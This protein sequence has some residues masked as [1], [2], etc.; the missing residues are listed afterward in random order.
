METTLQ[1]AAQAASR[2]VM[3]ACRQARAAKQDP[4]L[5]TQLLQ[6][7]TG[8]GAAVCQALYA[9]NPQEASAALKAAQEACGSCLE[10]LG[11]LKAAGIPQAGEALALCGQLA[12]ALEQAGQQP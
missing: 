11:Q 9:P 6:A 12:K 3:D 2:A 4:A 5:V 7:G 8:V 10:L 1:G